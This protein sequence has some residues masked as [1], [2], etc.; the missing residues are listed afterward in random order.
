M[1]EKCYLSWC[2]WIPLLKSHDGGFDSIPTGMLV[3]QFA[4][5]YTEIELLVLEEIHC[6]QRLFRYK[7]TK[8]ISRVC[9]WLN[10]TSNKPFSL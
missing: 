8:I 2:K 4:S 10:V 6:P 7:P 3:G 9:P 5:V 1:V